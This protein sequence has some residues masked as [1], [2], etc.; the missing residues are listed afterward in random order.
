MKRIAVWLAAIGLVAAGS[1]GS[2]A[3]GAVPAAA[4]TR[5]VIEPTASR[6]HLSNQLNG[7][8][9]TSASACTAVG[10]PPLGLPGNR[11][12]TLAE[13][14]DGRRWSIQPTPN[15]RGSAGAAL[16]GV[17]CSSR[18]AC[19]AVG[20][21]GGGRYTQTLAERWNGSRWSIQPTPNPAPASELVGVSCP[22]ANDC[23]AVGN[24]SAPTGPIFGLIERWNG[25]RWAIAGVVRP[26]GADETFLTAVSCSNVRRCTAVGS[27]QLTT[28]PI[29]PY[30]L[31]E[32][33]TGSR[34][35]QQV[36]PG[37]GE[38]MAVSCPAFFHCA[39]VGDQADSAGSV[40]DAGDAVERPGMAG[41]AH[42]RAQGRLAGL[43][44][45]RLVRRGDLLHGR[46]VGRGQPRV[47]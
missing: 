2:P 39:A 35:R 44:A 17:S 9:C 36:T 31:A 34:W 6:A 32:R 46:R 23:V 22:A 25:L 41:A 21:K 12:I 20:L 5:W 30:P 10:G 43:P 14:W 1:A 33:W 38:L 45:G 24:Y 19:T 7:V 47:R 3:A 8:S 42:T 13:R 29:G 16:W 15:P 37:K 28:S 26:A 18:R 11:A 40:D 27:F 4:G